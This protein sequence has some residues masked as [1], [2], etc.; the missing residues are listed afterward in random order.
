MTKRR[1]IIKKIRDAAKA[2]GLDVDLNEGGNH[3]ILSVDG[4]TI[5]VPR[6]NEVRENTARTI[7]EQAESKLGKDWWK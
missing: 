2:K 5:P 6:H 3:S 7:Y 1:D 4:V